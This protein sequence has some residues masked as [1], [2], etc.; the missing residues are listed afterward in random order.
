MV[1]PTSAAKFACAQGVQ[2]TEAIT[3]VK[4][5]AVQAT[6]VLEPSLGDQIQ[7]GQATN[8]LVNGR[9]MEGTDKVPTLTQMVQNT[10]ESTGII[11][12]MDKE[13]T[14]GQMVKNTLVTG[15]MI[16]GPG[17]VPTRGQMAPNTLVSL[18][19]V[20]FTD[21]GFFFMQMVL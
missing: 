4:V 11:K 12:G 3:S 14:R 13:L 10:L 15:R 5:P 21:K 19:I 16:K 9:I 20:K 6:H 18:G 7:D 8:T 1:E 17:K 2:A